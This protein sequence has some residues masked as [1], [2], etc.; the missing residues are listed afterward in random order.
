M[1]RIIFI[2]ILCVFTVSLT[3]A[4]YTPL[5]K[6]EVAP[7]AYEDVFL[8]YV[9]DFQSRIL[10]ISGG[11][12]VGQIDYRH[13]LYGYGQ[14][15]SDGG[16]MILGKFRNGELLQGI[17]IGRD[18][19]TVG[20][21]EFYCSYSLSTGNLEYICIKGELIVPPDTIA[22]DYKFLTQTF[23][24]GDS[25]VGELYKGLRHGLGIYYYAAGGLW[26]GTYCNDIRDGFGAWF[27][28]SNDM[29]IGHWA[30]EDERRTIYI[31]LK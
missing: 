17:S 21:K 1:K 18:N 16:D 12:Y 13:S 8:D 11:Q 3:K 19:V 7:S 28:V 5:K 29:L 4:Q 26:F 22:S 31:P 14:Y 2:F 27:K 9:S 15:V 23:S 20:N 24:N 6:Y 25:Y 30:G 10:S